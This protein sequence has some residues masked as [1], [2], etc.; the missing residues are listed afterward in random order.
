VKRLNALALVIAI[1]S[2]GP[3]CRGSEPKGTIEIGSDLPTSG[4]DA[5]GQYPTMFGLNAAD[6]PRSTATGEGW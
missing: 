4:F 5:T 3:V 2:L 6:L 1:V